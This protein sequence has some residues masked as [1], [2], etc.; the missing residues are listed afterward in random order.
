M[1]YV[2]VS[3]VGLKWIFLEADSEIARKLRDDFTNGV[4]ELLVPDIFPV[5]VAHAITRAERANR[6]SAAEGE[7]NMNNMLTLLPAVHETLKLIP[8][9]Y[10]LSSKFRIGVY[11]FLYVA[12]AEREQ[13]ELITADQR[14][15][16]NLGVQFP[17]IS[18]DSL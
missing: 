10:E 6:I 8:Q 5:E 4:I 13:C 16:L 7:R 18:L 11:D 1:M 12:L 17:I 2:L 3:C 9:A 14:L 15:I